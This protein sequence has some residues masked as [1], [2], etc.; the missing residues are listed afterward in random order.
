MAELVATSP[1]KGLLPVTIGGLT[2]SEPA[3]AMMTGISPHTGEVAQASALL[4]QATGC[5]LPAPNRLTR[6]GDAMALWT[7][8]NR[9]MLIGAPAPEGLAETAALTDQSDAW[10]AVT[11]EGPGAALVLARLCPL[12]LRDT[13]FPEGTATRSEIFHMQAIIARTGPASFL[14]LT[15]RSMAGTLVHDL[16]TAARAVAARAEV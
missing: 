15:F 10:V 13:A 9:W 4:K 3:H 1:A 2:L 6:S 7:G 11:I 16:T 14:V 8:R 12:D 5:D